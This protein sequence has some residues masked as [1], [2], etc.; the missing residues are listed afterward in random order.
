MLEEEVTMRCDLHVHSRHSGPVTLPLLG[1]VLRE[2]YSEPGAVYEVARRRGMNLVTLTDHDTIA[3]ALELAAQ[4]DVFVSEEVTCLLPERRELH[5]GV[6]DITE[7]QHLRIAERRRDAEAL[8]AYLAEQRIPACLNHP[9]SA[10]TGRRAVSDLHLGLAGTTLVETRNGML[11]AL[12]ND[13]A[14]RAGALLGRAAVGG[15]DGH[16]LASVARAFTIV[17]GAR[18]K[19]E[20]LAGLRAGATVPA[21]RSGSYARLTGDILRIVTGGV[22]EALAPHTAG[23]LRRLALLA[24]LPLLPFIPLATMVQV[25]KER[26]WA[27]HVFARYRS[28]ATAAAP[29]MA[30]LKAEA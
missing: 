13:R 7:Q 9:F 1:R 24:A 14:L 15:S 8:F 10:L 25:V 5:V 20:F 21:G 11:P 18:D 22:A 23:D 2:S 16:T 17:Q 26:V 30:R 12:T 4:A 19:A 27:A 6:Y 3:G 28:D 29:A